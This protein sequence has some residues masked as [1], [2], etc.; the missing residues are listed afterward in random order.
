M[1]RKQYLKFLDGLFKVIFALLAAIVA[2][3]VVIGFAQVFYRYVLM[4]A[5]FW[6]EETLRYLHIWAIFLGAGLGVS[7]GMHVAIDAIFIALG[8]KMGAVLARAVQLIG[9]IFAIIIIVVGWNFSTFNTAVVSPT[10]QIPMLYVYI[11][12]PVG[13]VLML[14]FQIGEMLKPRKEKLS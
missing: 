5:L 13:G 7:R 9:C 2:A 10:M 11:A 6:S 8:P 3:M 14:L 1:I 4:A 12:I